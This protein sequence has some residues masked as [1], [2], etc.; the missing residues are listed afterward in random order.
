MD[1]R[2]NSQTKV[3][4]PLVTLPIPT[5]EDPHTH[6]D[7]LEQRLRQMRASDEVIT[8]TDFDGTPMASLSAKFRMP[9][10]ERYTGIEEGIARGLWPESSP[11]DSKGKKPSGGQ[12]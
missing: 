4:P 9:K 6:M 7:R 10:I 1:S 11:T 2:P 12:R 5:S 8:W 3:G